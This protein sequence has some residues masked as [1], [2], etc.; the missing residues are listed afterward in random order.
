MQKGLD[1]HISYGIHIAYIARGNYIGRYANQPHEKKYYHLIYPLDDGNRMFFCSD[2]YVMKSGRFVLIPPGTMYGICADSSNSL[3]T[4][5]V[6]FQVE[7]DN[8]YRYVLLG[9]K[10]YV[11]TDGAMRSQLLELIDNAKARRKSR[12]EWLNLTLAKMLTDTT[13]YLR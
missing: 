4:L 7:R 13:N 6:R 5:E 8:Y 3:R 9:P 10:E 1:G 12:N 11:D 2:T